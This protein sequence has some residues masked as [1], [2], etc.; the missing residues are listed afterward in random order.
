MNTSFQHDLTNDYNH[1]DTQIDNNQ[2]IQFNNDERIK[3]N[4]K[5]LICCNQQIDTCIFSYFKYL[6]YI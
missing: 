6:F 3:T 5:K 2:Y 1:L 4:K